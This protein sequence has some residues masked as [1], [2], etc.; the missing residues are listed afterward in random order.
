MP[1]IYMIIIVII[2]HIVLSKTEFGLNT[3][4]IGGNFKAARL[5]GLEE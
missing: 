2:G 5:A 3:Y 4:A 1:V